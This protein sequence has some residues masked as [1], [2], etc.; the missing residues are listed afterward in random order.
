MAQPPTVTH[1]PMA[2]PKYSES[3]LFTVATERTTKASTKVNTSSATTAWDHL[4]SAGLSANVSPFIMAEY[5]NAAQIPPRICTPMYM[6]PSFGEH[7]PRPLQMIAMV[8]A[9]LKWAPEHVPK[10]KIMHMSDAAIENAPA[11]E[12]LSTLRPTVRTS[13][14][15]PRNSLQSFAAISGSAAASSSWA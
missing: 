6:A 15:V 11:A 8:T 10:A 2:K 9:G 7:L 13:I 1:M 12:P 3:A 14:K 4:E 5:V